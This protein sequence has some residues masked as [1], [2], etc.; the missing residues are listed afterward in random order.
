[1]AYI[2]INFSELY[3]GKVYVS[4]CVSL[5]IKINRLFELINR[6]CGRIHLYTAASRQNVRVYIHTRVGSV[7][8]IVIK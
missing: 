6:K 3:K 1:M 2:S 8:I 5:K 7:G 4:V